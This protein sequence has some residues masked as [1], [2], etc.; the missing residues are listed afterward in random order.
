M[1]QA[2]IAD[3][4]VDWDFFDKNKR[5]VVEDKVKIE[6]VKIENR[7]KI[8]A[9]EINEGIKSVSTAKKELLSK[10]FNSLNSREE[11]EE[12]LDAFDKDSFISTEDEEFLEYINISGFNSSNAAF[13]SIKTA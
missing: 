10:Y 6:E 13:S 1:K 11:K 2:T 9:V 8:S 5:Q 4:E 7:D 12:I 3:S